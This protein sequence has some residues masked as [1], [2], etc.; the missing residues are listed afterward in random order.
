M[1]VEIPKNN[2]ANAYCAVNEVKVDLPKED[3][4]WLKSVRQLKKYDD[5]LGGW[6]IDAG[7]HGIMITTNEL[8]TYAFKKYTDRLSS[9]GKIT[10][11]RAFAI[12]HST[13]SEQLGS[14]I[15]IKK[16]Y[17]DISNPE[18]D[19]MLSNGLGVAEHNIVSE[20]NQMKFYDAAPPIVYMMMIIWDHVVKTFLSHEELRNV[21][22][23][24]ITPV[25]VTVKEIGDKLSK[26]T[27]E[28]N[29]GCMEQSWIKEALSG[30]DEIGLASKFDNGKFKI[31][32]RK[33]RG[34]TLDWLLEKIEKL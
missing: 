15:N 13:R 21:K 11:R 8:R 7:T 2:G 16:D 30:F 12:L 27:P 26:F 28:T 4:L 22:G 34:K 6:D 32:F 24:K 5:D 29:P 18:L 17:G 25:V 9:D 14:F 10:I 33:H 23:N 3:G 31:R 1:V 20:I 19:D